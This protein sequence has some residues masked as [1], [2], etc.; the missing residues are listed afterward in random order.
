[1]KRVRVVPVVVVSLTLAAAFAFGQVGSVAPVAPSRSGM[2]SYIQGAV[3][4]DD[5]Q[6]PDPIVA[7]YPYMQDNGTLHT[8]EGRA[9]VQMNPGVTQWLGESGS[10]RMVTSRFI[11]T[12]VEL[13]QGAAT[14]ALTEVNKDNSFTVVCKDATAVIAKAGFY[15]FYADPVGIKVFE[16]LARVQ[17]GEQNLEVPAGK[18]LVMDGQKAS[19]EKFD[20]EATDALDRFSGH[21]G[22]LMAAANASSARDCRTSFTFVSN[23]TTRP[24]MGNWNW[25][26]YY[27]LWTYIPYMNRYCDPIWGYCYYN[28]MGAWN[29]YY[30]PQ[31]VYSY[32]YGGRG[33]PVGTTPIMTAPRT[34]G[35]Y[36]GAVAA[37]SA[38]MSSPGAGSGSSAA[39]AGAAGSAGH[40]SAGGAAAGG[41]ASG[42]GGG[43]HGK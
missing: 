14:V 26:P 31:P 18:M 8:A 34:S 19:V 32:G 11:D 15:H 3:Y 30:R 22:E 4:L 38:A 25:N 35:G 24:C 10:L 12:R 41:G 5:K 43:G 17:V 42:G 27:G 9:E 40:G 20:K 6:I 21:R 36:S 28:P 37:S 13:V 33:T 16:G 23:S 2:V 29:Y 39:A 1:M 7:Q